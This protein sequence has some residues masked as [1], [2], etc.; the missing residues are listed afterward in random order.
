MRKENIAPNLITYNALIHACSQAGAT[1]AAPSHE[2]RHQRLSGLAG[3]PE[4]HH[5]D[6]DAAP[7]DA[8]AATELARWP[9]PRRGMAR[10]GRAG[11]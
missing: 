5:A 2:R 6:A 8:A 11:G 3:Q 4:G 1:D 10:V 7:L 9:Q